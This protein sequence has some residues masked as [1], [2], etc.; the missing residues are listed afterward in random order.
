MVLGENMNLFIY[1]SSHRLN[2]TATILQKN[3]F[4]FK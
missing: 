3:Y 4:G 2:S 1:P